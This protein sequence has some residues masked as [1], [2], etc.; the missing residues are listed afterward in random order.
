MH[1]KPLAVRSCIE[2]ANLSISGHMN[3]I[4]GQLCKHGAKPK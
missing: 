1:L 2:H 3:Y 4:I